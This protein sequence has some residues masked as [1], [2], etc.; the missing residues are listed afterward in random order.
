MERVGEESN[1]RKLV[2]SFTNVLHRKNGNVSFANQVMKRTGLMN[3]TYGWVMVS[4]LCVGAVQAAEISGKVTLE[5]KPPP[6]ITIKMA[7]QYGS[8]GSP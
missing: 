7:H 1:K 8:T 4:A 5:G 6:E 2:K 3:K